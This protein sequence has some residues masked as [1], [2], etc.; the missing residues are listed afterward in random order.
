MK[1]IA[2]HSNQLCLRGSEIALYTYAD[3]NEKILG[4]IEIY[5]PDGTKVI[6]TEENCKPIELILE[7]N[8]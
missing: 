3:Y 4:N 7:L 1:T 6:G 2:F 5:F 8:N